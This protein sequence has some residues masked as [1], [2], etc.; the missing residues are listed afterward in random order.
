MDIAQL[1][2]YGGALA[3]AVSGLWRLV[4]KPGAQAIATRETTAPVLAK[5]AKMHPPL[6]EWVERT[7]GRLDDI[8]SNLRERRHGR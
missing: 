1:I 7:D 8:E 5:L 2:L 4:I 6:P 3:G